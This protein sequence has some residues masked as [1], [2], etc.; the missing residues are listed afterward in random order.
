MSPIRPDFSL[1]NINKPNGMTSH[2]VVAKIRRATGIK[3]VGHAGTLDP[4]ATGV[5]IICLGQATRL[6]Q[7][8]MGHDKTYRARVRLG[9]TTDTDDAEG[10]ITQTADID[11]TT[12]TQQRI[13]AELPQF[14]GNLEQ[15][16]PMYSA[17][18][19][20]G[21]KLYELARQGQTVELEPRSITIHKIN[22]IE[23]NFPEFTIEVSCSAGTYIRSL[24]RDI[25]ETIHTGAH[26][27]GLQR[28]AIGDHVEFHIQNAVDLQTFLDAV[29]QQGQHED[30]H[31]HQ[32]LLSPELAVSDLPNI[33][34]PA[35]QCERLRHG[36]FV[37]I[38][39]Q[40]IQNTSILT[41]SSS[42]LLN[43]PEQPTP[44][45]AYD[46]DHIFFA[47]LEQRS[48]DTET[49]IGLWKPLRVFR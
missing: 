11:E 30:N 49:G 23:W 10:Q 44:I 16:P 47:L 4:M 5:L 36:G 14:I 8:V 1:L 25:G 45:C 46:Q 21:K 28:T 7:Y 35:E 18:K 19:K 42:N 34:L 39:Q 32:F 43:Q 33:H 40:D 20:G 13:E 2:D 12:I 6:S 29:Q 27:A 41:L 24:A 48:F 37:E 15:I 26:L 38:N 17:I 3:K 22:F 31:W 9:I